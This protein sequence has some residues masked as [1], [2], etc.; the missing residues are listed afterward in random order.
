MKKQLNQD[1]GKA[2]NYSSFKGKT[3]TQKL[4][5]SLWR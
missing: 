2:T 1:E 3:S 4:T 5:P